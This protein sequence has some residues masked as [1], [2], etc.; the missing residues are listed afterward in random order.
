MFHENIVKWHNAEAAVTPLGHA[1]FM[2]DRSQAT[3]SKQRG[4]DVCVLTSER[5]PL[6]RSLSTAAFMFPARQFCSFGKQRRRHGI[7]QALNGS[8]YV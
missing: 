4:G 5:L 6:Q 7:A 3:D 1:L 2:T 8:H